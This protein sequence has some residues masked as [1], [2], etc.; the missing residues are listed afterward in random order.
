M[1]S[2][3][4]F[5]LELLATGST[6]LGIKG[7]KI[8]QVRLALPPI[9]EQR[10][11]SE[12]IQSETAKLDVLRAESEHAIALLKERRSALIAAAVTGQINVRGLVTEPEVA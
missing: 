6:A 3:C 7:S 11:I 10:A 12:F 4:Q 5:N 8:G 1:G 2:S 9:G